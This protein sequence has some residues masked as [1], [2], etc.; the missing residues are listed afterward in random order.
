MNEEFKEI[1]NLA[2]Q[3]NSLMKQ[4]YE[5]TKQEVQEILKTNS[6][7]SNR[8]EHALDSLLECVDFGMGEKEFFQ[9]IEKLNK[10]DRK[11]ADDYLKFY[12]E[13]KTQESIN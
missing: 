9:I 13:Q 1:H 12:E 5:L 11:A 4:K 10:I 8:M 2:S 6:S 7:D 3:I